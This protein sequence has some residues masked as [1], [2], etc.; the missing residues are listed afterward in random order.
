MGPSEVSHYPDGLL[1]VDISS[2][3]FSTGW[4]EF[5]LEFSQ[6]F[7]RSF[8]CLVNSFH[9]SLLKIKTRQH[10]T[11]DVMLFIIDIP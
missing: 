3:S 1:L 5:N 4:R 11:I 8:G 6:F 7:P 9:S 2:T 10:P